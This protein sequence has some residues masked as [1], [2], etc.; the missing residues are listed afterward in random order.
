[1]ADDGPELSMTVTAGEVMNSPVLTIHTHAT[2]ADAA[3]VML[4]NRIGAVVVLDENEHYAGML[5]ERMM[6]PEESMVSF[7]RGRAFRI[8]G[9]EVGDFENIEETIAEVKL[10]KVGDVMNKQNPTAAR[11]THLADVV[12]AMVSRQVHH[13]CVVE[14]RKPVG[15]I[16]RHDLLRLFVNR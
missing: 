4:L 15:I 11:D 14:D 10:L 3:Q 8:L 1:M 7:M 5:T 13:I 16:S 2:V 12:E 6:L 9:H